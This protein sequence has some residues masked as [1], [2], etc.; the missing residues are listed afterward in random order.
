MPL[1]R[2]QKIMESI[3]RGVFHIF[4][5]IMHSL[6]VVLREVAEIHHMQLSG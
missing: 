3:E 1:G 4:E 2:L 6:M 5:G